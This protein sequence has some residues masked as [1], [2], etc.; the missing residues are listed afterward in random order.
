[1]HDRACDQLRKERYQRRVVDQA[2]GRRPVA[3]DID[4]EAIF[5]K[6]MKETPSGAMI[7]RAEK[8]RTQQE[9]EIFQEEVGVLEEASTPKLAATPM[10]SSQRRR[11]SG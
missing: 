3:Q 10:P 4:Q 11:N 9:I 1:M 2:V 8:L 5:W 7:C 6:V